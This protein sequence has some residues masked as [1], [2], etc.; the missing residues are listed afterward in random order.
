MRIT[1]AT[2]HSVERRKAIRYRMRVPVIF[3]WDRARSNRFQGEGTTRD[4]SV[5]G[6]YV[7]TPTC[8]PVNS[9]VQME[10]VLLPPFSTS[11]ARITA[12]MKVLRV[13]HDIA[14][15]KRSGFSGA[16]KGF[17]LRAISKQLSIPIADSA[18]RL[19]GQA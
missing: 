7:L 17:V 13:E 16:G 5:S 4:V 10:V 19:E 11:K 6:I 12:E 14:G 1:R 9:I 18:E 3:R 2:E 8:P 15:K